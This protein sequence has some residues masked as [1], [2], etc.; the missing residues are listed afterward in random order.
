VA[1]AGVTGVVVRPI[2]VDEVGRFNAALREH[3]WLGH[4]LTGQV[5]RYVAVLDG[6]WVAVVGFGSAVLSCRARD[7]FVGWSREQQYSRLRHVANNQRFCVLPAGRRPNLASAVLSRVLTRLSGDYLAAY[8]HRVLA[9][10]T[11]TDPARHTG[12]C[13]AA[14]NFQ[15][16]GSTLGY[17]RSAGAYHHH[18]N[19][20]RVW[21]YR[22]HRDVRGILSA[23][24]PHP[25]LTRRDDDLADVNTL[26]LASGGGLLEALSELSDPRSKRGIRHQIASTLTMV[27]AATISGARSFRSVADY[28]ADLPPDALARLGARR[29]PVT[30]RPVAPSE[31]TI[32]RTVKDVDAEEA[33]TI[34]GTWLHAK[35]M[36]GV[37]SPKTWRGLALD[38]K[39]LKG[40]WEEV[41]TGAGKV[42]LF[43]A[44]THAEGVVVGQ[45]RI[46]ENTG[47]QTQMIPLLD[48]IAGAP[49]G[50]PPP[51]DSPPGDLSGVV[52]TA[53]AL[54]VHRRNVEQILARNG[55]YVL[56]VKRN[57]PILR[58]S[59]KALFAD[60][61]GAFPPSS[62]HV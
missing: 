10:E 1:G 47:E 35:V 53:D 54:H 11:F 33:D 19:P 48:Q 9:V 45:R 30:G 24:F 29:H 60:P 27:A 17:S 20:K 43:S 51:E 42:R 26:E 6:E 50:S 34:V 28:V 22:V 13:Y 18:G 59:I 31:A 55:E 21:M 40:A 7:E 14:A 56:T 58:N 8:G 36:A 12:A 23:T 3:H 4:R 49:P 39:T 37:V 16:V 2:F 62:R 5:L 61:D 41:D 32:R 46:P 57:Q 38:G 25:L 15:L 44:L 52:V